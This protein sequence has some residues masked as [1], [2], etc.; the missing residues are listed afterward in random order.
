VHGKTSK[1]A[2]AKATRI[3]KRWHRQFQRAAKRTQS[4]PSTVPRKYKGCTFN[5]V[6]GDQ[7]NS[8]TGKKGTSATGEQARATATTTGKNSGPVVAGSDST[9]QIDQHGATNAATTRGNNNST[10]QTNTALEAPGVG[11]TIAGAIA[12]P[13]GKALAVLLVGGV[14]WGIVAWRK[15]SVV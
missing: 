6:A 12:T 2:G 13:L 7:T 3:L 11:A 1:Q 4:A 14:V 8:A 9:S 10:G 15:K 5:V